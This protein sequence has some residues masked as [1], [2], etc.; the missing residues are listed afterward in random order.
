MKQA[1]LEPTAW[2]LWGCGTAHQATA[3]PVCSY[4]NNPGNFKFQRTQIIQAVQ[5]QACLNMWAQCVQ[6]YCSPP[7]LT[8]APSE[9]RQMWKRIS[10]DTREERWFPFHQLSYW[11]SSGCIC[12]KHAS[13]HKMKNK[14]KSTFSSK[15][16]EVFIKLLFSFN[17]SLAAFVMKLWS[18]LPL[19]G[20]YACLA[21][22]MHP[23][24][25]VGWPH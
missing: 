14:I 2:G 4:T 10:A 8:G 1:G 5:V 9:P 11:M 3:T 12:T 24:E 21:G 6:I 18:V 13:R 15:C 16:P 22:S 20:N 17:L 19:T 7:S 23:A 25:N